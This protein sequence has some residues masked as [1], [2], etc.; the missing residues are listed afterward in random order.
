M[1]NYVWISQ[2]WNLIFFQ[3]TSD[4]ETTKMKVGDLEKLYKF[5]V[6][7][8]LIWNHFIEEN[9]VWIFYKKEK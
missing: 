1:E 9:Y 8:F 5:I 3:T 6:D 7:N 2:I 4:V